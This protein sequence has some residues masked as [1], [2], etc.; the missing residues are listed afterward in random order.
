MMRSRRITDVL[1][2]CITDTLPFYYVKINKVCESGSS[3]SIMSG[4]GLDNR[5]IEV[6]SP[7]EAIG[8]FL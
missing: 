7:A 6:R 5:A 1:A 4:Y 8:F 3:V 2:I